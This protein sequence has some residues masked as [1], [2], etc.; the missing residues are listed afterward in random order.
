MDIIAETCRCKYS[1][2]YIFY[3]RIIFFSFIKCMHFLSPEGA[4]F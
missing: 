3:C 1:S 2:K 4:K